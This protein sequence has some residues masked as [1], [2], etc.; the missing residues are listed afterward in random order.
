MMDLSRNLDSAF[1]IRISEF[2][3]ARNPEPRT[4]NAERR[5]FP[6]RS[7]TF[8]RSGHSRYRRGFSFLEILF[9][10]IIIGI[11]FVMIA[12]V[13]PVAI[14]QTQ[15]N[16]NESTAVTLS[17]DAIRYIQESTISAAGSVASTTS[18]SGTLATF[19][20]QP[21]SAVGGLPTIQPLPVSTLAMTGLTSPFTIVSPLITG[22]NPNLSGDRRYSWFGLYRRDFLNTSAIS[23]PAPYAQVWV[24]AA[25][26]TA[27]GQTNY[28]S[29]PIVSAANFFPN[30]SINGCT[31]VGINGAGS[32]TISFANY[33]NT[34]PIRDGAFV[35]VTGYVTVSTPTA[36]DAANA[37]SIVGWY[38][39]LGVSVAGAANPS[40][41]LLNTPPTTSIISVNAFVLGKP[42]IPPNATVGTQV[43]YSGLA[44]DIT[45]TTGFVRVNN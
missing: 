43:S 30:S 23:I 22:V 38:S 41:Y 8:P 6:S 1:G 37:N 16:V 10:V 4:P 20:L 28:G 40:W 39:K 31:A 17:R 45:C 32:G 26:N 7:A 3:F 29:A 25:Q 34:G 5:P 21:T 12:A 27:E 11:G 44:Q 33:N 15:S 19:T 14:A 24:V 35:L 13:F 9:S 2:G 18:P 36:V 42:Y